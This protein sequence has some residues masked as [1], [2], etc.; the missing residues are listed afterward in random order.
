MFRNQHFD[1][2]N[3]FLI[4]LALL[5]L[6]TIGTFLIP[7]RGEAIVTEK[8][9]NRL[10]RT[11]DKWIGEDR[12][13]EDLIYRVLDTDD[14]LF[15]YYNSA[16]NNP[17]WLYVGYYGTKKGGSTGHV[18]KYCYT[19]AGWTI[20]E[21]DDVD[22]HWKSRNINVQVKKMLLRKGDAQEIVLF[23]FHSDGDKVL[24]YGPKLKINKFWGKIIRN[25]A[26]GAFV[27]ISA[28]VL[29]NDVD[30]TLEYEKAFASQL[31]ELFPQ[32][33]PIEENET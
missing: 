32:C 29:N 21:M 8:R 19:G 4:S 11:I 33:W 18:P 16:D 15:R 28:P 24:D 5:G 17:L 13:F 7:L 20:V 22:I 14:N 2:L 10:P 30:E 27:R 9:L 12:Q 23:W 3:T 25:R 31:L 1:R 26:D 6:T